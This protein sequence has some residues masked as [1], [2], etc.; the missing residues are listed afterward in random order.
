MPKRY[1][2]AELIRLLNRDGWFLVSIRGSHHKYKHSI[3][4]A[5]II[6]PH[7]QKDI[8]AGISSQILKAA[9]LKC[10]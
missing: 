5:S 7:P 8:P 9:G 3:K 10:R 2:S 4:Q 1:N 6:I